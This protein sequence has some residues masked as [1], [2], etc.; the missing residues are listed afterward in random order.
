MDE[1]EL[2][3]VAELLASQMAEKFPVL[4]KEVE[5]V[6]EETPTAPAQTQTDNNTT[7]FDMKAMVAEMMTQ[8]NQRD[9]S[10]VMNVM[11]EDKLN[12]AMAQTP[13]FEEYLNDKDDYGRVRM[14]Q[15]TQGSYEEKLSI[16][17]SVQKS[18]VQASS[19]N[20]GRP[21]VVSEKVS[22]RVKETETKYEDIDKKL[23]TGAYGSIQE[24][25]DDYFEIFDAEMTAIQ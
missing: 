3:K 18:F 6:A 13:G 25:A 17:D 2:A 15:I 24:F 23:E 10:K 7:P 14:D 21:P 9:D 22:K 20:G 19:N 12:H 4:N 16:L 8:L 1:E 11:F 5:T